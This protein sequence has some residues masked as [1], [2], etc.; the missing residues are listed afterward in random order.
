MTL[1]EEKE[2]FD[3]EYLDHEDIYPE[4]EDPEEPSKYV[5]DEICEYWF[6]YTVPL[7]YNIHYNGISKEVAVLNK[8]TNEYE[9]VTK[10]VCKTPFILCGVSD[11]PNDDSVNYKIR[12]S[13]YDGKVKEFWARQYELLSKSDL[14]RLSQNYFEFYNWVISHFII[15]FISTRID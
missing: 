3:E 6:K 1:F 8:K 12:Y 15:F 5:N 14:N 9:N 13:A 4:N 2:K 10:D 7:G 11:S